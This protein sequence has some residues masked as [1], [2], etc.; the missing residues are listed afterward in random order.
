MALV[1]L[2]LCTIGTAQLQ[3]ISAKPIFRYVEF[4]GEQKW[5]GQTHIIKYGI[6]L[7]VV[8][9]LKEPHKQSM[10]ADLIIIDENGDARIER[11]KRF[12]N[13]GINEWHEYDLDT[14]TLNP[15]PYQV[16]IKAWSAVREEQEGISEGIESEETIWGDLYL[17]LQV[18]ED[19]TQP[20]KIPGFPWEGVILGIIV[21]IPVIISRKGK[22]PLRMRNG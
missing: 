16:R 20:P 14:N 12:S 11:M 21:A 5:P 22:A 19:Q 6:M 2:V 10:K 9:A 13:E 4:N 8:A 17:S 3:E 15:G 7:R 18:S 1:F